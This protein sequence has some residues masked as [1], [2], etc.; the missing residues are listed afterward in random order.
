MLDEFQCTQKTP[1]LKKIGE[2]APRPNFD[3]CVELMVRKLAWTEDYAV[4]K[5]LP[6]LT[7]W[8]VKTVKGKTKTASS[9][10]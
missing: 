3:T 6:V 9:L 1:N 8:Q 5:M 7:R 4:E 2:S 10:H